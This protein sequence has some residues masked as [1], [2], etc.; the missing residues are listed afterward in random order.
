MVEEK[1]RLIE[2]KTL[3]GISISHQLVVLT[4]ITEDDVGGLMMTYLIWKVSTW[5]LTDLSLEG[6][7]AVVFDIPVL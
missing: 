5:L 3:R 6:N 7:G 4:F 1:T 2:M